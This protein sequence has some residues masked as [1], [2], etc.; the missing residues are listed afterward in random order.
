[1]ETARSG[2]RRAAI[3]IGGRLPLG[4][5]AARRR[6]RGEPGA[7]ADVR[8]LA[9]RL[10][11]ADRGRARPGSRSAT[12]SAGRSPTA[13]RR[14]TCSSARSRSA[15]CSCSRS[16][17]STS[18]C[19]SGSS[20]GIPA[21]GSIRWSRRSLLF[22][23]MSV[24]LASVIA[25][26]RP[27]RG[28][29]A[30][31]A[32]ADRRTAVLGLD[33]RQHRRDLRDRVL[34]R[35]RARHGPGARGRRGGALL[36]AASSSP[37]AE[38]LLRPS[39]RSLAAAAAASRAVVVARARPRAAR[40]G[41]AAQNWSPLYRESEAPRAGRPREP[42]GR[43]PGC[44]SGPRGTRDTTGC[45]RRRTTSRVPPLRQLVPERDVP[46]RSDPDAVRV[47]RLPPPRAR[48]HARGAKDA[49]HRPRRR[50]GAEAL[51]RDFRDSRCR[52]SS[53]TPT[54]STPRT[55]GSRC[56]ATPGSTSRST[57]GAGSCT[58]NDER[59]DVIVVDAFYA[60][61][62]PFHLTTLE[63]LAAAARPARRPAGSSRERDR[64]ARAGTS[65]AC[66]ASICEDVPL[67]VPDGAPP[68]GLRAGRRRPG[69]HPQRHPRRDRAAA[70]STAFLAEPWAE[71]RASGAPDGAR[72]RRAIRDRLDA[73][74]RIDDVPVL[75]DDYAPTDALLVDGTGRLFAPKNARATSYHSSG[76]VFS[77]AVASSS[78]TSTIA[79]PCSATMRPNVPSRD[80]VG[81]LER[82]SASRAHG[83]AAVGVPPR[84]TWP[85]TVTRGLEA[86][87]LPRSRARAPRR[88]R[89]GARARTGRSSRLAGDELL[90]A[91]RVRQLV[92]LGDDDDREVL[93]AARAA[94]SSSAQASSTRRSGCSGIRITSAPP[95]IP[96]MTR[97][98]AGV[99][100]HHL[101]DHHAVVR[102]GRR[103]QAVDRL[104]RDLR[105]RCRSR[106]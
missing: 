77:S 84:W 9:L 32:R 80:E 58:R 16:R 88:R 50:L 18:G 67:R 37:L 14:R 15:R 92:A 48:V 83:R 13:A 33:R 20:S 90:L 59:W 61:G 63:F 66:S 30:R 89:R 97:D 103:V 49:R 28:A 39:R 44:S 69:R 24:V 100:A 2:E 68:P 79:S 3:A 55:A 41:S 102:L 4:R 45:R 8:Q 38:R 94:A 23:P 73:A 47:H 19:S 52:R 57:T 35:S 65:R 10:G 87:A 86:G 72:S 27:A 25:D 1:M 81:G 56:R 5:G 51:C 99:A 82:R 75:T 11:R 71:R 42:R 104:G 105:R 85:R 78:E 60:D 43:A 40:L 95:A 17:S 93:A 53:S 29:L 106:T 12:G 76:T 26:R 101:D 54:S 22:G 98:P 21:R 64:G 96:L 91:R 62:V 7:R 36:A 34:A 74:G 6:D 70:P 31:A 46:R